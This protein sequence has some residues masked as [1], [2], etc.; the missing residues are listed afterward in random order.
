MDGPVV[1]AEVI[2][3]LGGGRRTTQPLLAGGDRRLEPAGVDP[4]GAGQRIA[5]PEFIEDRPADAAHR[6][7]GESQAPLG[8]EAVHRLHQAEGAGGD[9][10]VEGHGVANPRGHFACGMVDQPE[11]ARQEFLSRI[12][13]VAGAPAGPQRVGR[14]GGHGDSQ[15]EQEALHMTE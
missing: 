11:I 6:E 2:G 15:E 4:F 12:E 8:L 9:E 1:D 13:V 7:G 14:S 10:L 5:R 3:D